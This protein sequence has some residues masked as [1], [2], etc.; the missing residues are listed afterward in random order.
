MPY[1]VISKVA[2][3]VGEYYKA[4][5]ELLKRQNEMKVLFKYNERLVQTVEEFIAHEKKIVDK[6]NALCRLYLDSFQKYCSAKNL[7]LTFNVKPIKCIF[8]K[9]RISE[10][11]FHLEEPPLPPVDRTYQ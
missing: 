6:Y 4:K 2:E 3:I 10:W 9:V 8:E 1:L 5:P 7:D 11:Q